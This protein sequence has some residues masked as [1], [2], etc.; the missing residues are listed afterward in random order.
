MEDSQSY[1][2]E[3][4]K[5]IIK[6][7][8]LE[9]LSVIGSGGYGEVSLG[10]Y[11]PTRKRV[12]IKRL[13]SQE[14]NNR[15]KELYLREVTCMATVKHQFLLRLVGFTIQKP[16]C[17]VTKY[18]PNNSLYNAIHGDSNSIPLTPTELNIICYGIAIGMAHL[19][20]K[21][22]IHRDLKSQNVLLDKY[23]L[24]VICDFGSSKS[25]DLSITQTG[26]GGTPNYMAPEFLKNLKY[27]EKV[28]VYSYGILLW[29]IISG[30]S[31][32]EGLAPA[33]VLCLV[34]IEGNRPEIP[35][36]IPT[37]FKEL[38]TMCWNKNPEKRPSFNDLVSL[39]HDGAVEIPGTV[40]SEFQEF[41]QDYTNTNV[42]PLIASTIKR[43]I[44]KPV[45]NTLTPTK[46]D[47]RIPLERNSS[48]S[49]QLLLPRQV[50][51]P[52]QFIQ[53]A[54]AFLVSLSGGTPSQIRNAIYFFESQIGNQLLP[55]ISL[56]KPFLALAINSPPEISS[57]VS[58]LLAKFAQKSAILYGI[59]HVPDLKNYVC[60]N[61]L[62]LFLYIINFLQEKIDLELIRAL[63][64][65]TNNEEAGEK[66][67]VLLCKILNI[68]KG[69]KDITNNIIDFYVSN[70]DRFS[71]RK[72]GHL[73]L[74]TLFNQKQLS[75]KTIQLY[76]QS[77]IISNNISAY[78]AL[79]SSGIRP[80]G[81]KI[82]T[83]CSHIVSTD[84]NLRLQSMEFVRRFASET[85]G[86]SLNQIVKALL[87]SVILFSS[88]EAML[89]LCRV[90]DDNNKAFVFL[91]PELMS[92]W[93]EV[94]SKKSPQF[95]ILFVLITKHMSIIFTFAQ[96]LT[97]IYNALV[98]G[99]QEHFIA[100]LQVFGMN[101]LS[102]TFIKNLKEK[103]VIDLICNKL[104][105]S[106][107]PTM[108]RSSVEFFT[109]ISSL[110]YSESY[111]KLILHLLNQ[112]K[113]NNEA[114]HE[115]IKILS[116]LCSQKDTHIT[117][118][119][120]NVV[121]VLA[122]YPNNTETQ[123]YIQKLV[124]HLRDGGVTIP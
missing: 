56:W 105:L 100:I 15:G 82:Q 33:Q 14:L 96:T 8:D 113:Q 37:N 62:D 72:G 88:E 50:L 46:I 64:N 92:K 20:E 97:F 84:I 71:D 43:I 65:L 21:K 124:S 111:N 32:F 7:E 93:T 104:C 115:C 85:K 26:Q 5:Y 59:I 58:S 91:Q 10:I 103:G 95:V 1:P 34:V 119:D 123:P 68:L 29:E 76:F 39:F 13:H 42:S 53:T 112:V 24:P 54:N 109:H 55:T 114:S 70:V 57:S 60:V 81:Y 75:E 79:F 98:N 63:A 101:P 6:Y 17:I 102:P 25:Q 94:E 78:H 35:E 41:I 27:D 77:S 69:N 106:K 73:M 61:T 108:I 66:P 38:L 116:S 36:G 47:D 117:F 83:I 23:K 89:L 2:P 45:P 3:T 122:R 118:I 74:Q 12:A 22:I 99:Q 51:P 11:K 31:P 9:F 52:N 4:H 28:D 16:Y 80:T 90:A 121:A 40:P 19:H 87:D 48:R 67:V 86:E 110:V 107:Q 49:V 18:I 44:R 30:H 120:A